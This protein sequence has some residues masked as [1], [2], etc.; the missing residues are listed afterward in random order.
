MHQ[1]MGIKQANKS[2][3]LPCGRKVVASLGLNLSLLRL[4]VRI[5]TI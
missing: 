4:T 1:E 3:H 5:S 2:P